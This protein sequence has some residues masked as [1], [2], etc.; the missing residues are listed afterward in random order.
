MRARCPD[1]NG[2]RSPSTVIDPSLAVRQFAGALPSAL[3]SG[4]TFTSGTTEQTASITPKTNGSQVVGAFG[5]AFDEVRLRPT[6]RLR[7]TA[8]SRAR[9]GVIRAARSRPLR[10][11]WP[12]RH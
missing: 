11:P 12:D 4:V 9:P 1:D 7:S 6:Q 5:N 8:S 3:Q 2:Y 10:S